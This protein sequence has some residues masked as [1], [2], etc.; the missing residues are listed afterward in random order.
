MTV[1]RFFTTAL[2]AFL[3]LAT[4]GIAGD[5]QYLGHGRLLTNDV[6]GDTNDRWRTGSY[7]ASRVWGPEWAGRLPDRFGQV[8]EFRFNGEILAPENLTRPAPGD[9]PYA[10]VLSFGL[11][12]HFL[13]AR[14]ELSVGADLVVTG[15][16]TGLDEL[17]PVLHDVLG[18]RDL[19]KA[20]RKAQIGN[21]VTPTLVAEAGREF[22]LAGQTRLRPFIEGR[23]GIETLVRAGA[24][25]TIGPVGVDGLMIREPVTGQRYRVIDNPFAGLAFVI[26][27]DVAYVEDSEF[28]PESRGFTLTDE[29]TRVRAGV[30]WENRKGASAFYGLTWL[31]EEFQAQREGQFVGSVRLNVKF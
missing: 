3:S 11:H 17:Q 21:D 27:A 8:L 2:L 16:Q 5:R 28:L 23:W 12:T 18:G 9:R 13:V 26:G 31:S 24:D 29:R 25:L 6:L 22:T 19:S 14:T 30:H 1:N 7:A 20:T 4:V 15:P 10:G